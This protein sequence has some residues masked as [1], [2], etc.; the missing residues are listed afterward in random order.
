MKAC[1]VILG[2]SLLLLAGQAFAG[3]YDELQATTCK[4]QSGDGTGTGVLVT[5][6]VGHATR[7]WVWTAAHVVQDLRQ[8]D[9]TF[10]NATV[11]QEYRDGGRQIGGCKIEA[12]VVAY[13]DP[14]T[15]EDLALLE[16]LQDDWR[17]TSVSAK[18]DLTASIQPVGTKLVHVGCGLGFESLS[19][20]IVSQTD[21]QPPQTGKRFDQTTLPAYPGCSG[22]GVYLEDGR[23]VGMLTLGAGPGLNFIIP[24]RRIVPWAKKMGIAWALDPALPVSPIVDRESSV[25]RESS[26]AGILTDSATAEAE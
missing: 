4:V 16:V 8:P 18:F 21:V 25:T 24:M 3:V 22:G 10:R 20:G 2:L 13:S 6:Q 1:R 12:K 23:Y 17:P 11:S 9:G 14:D 19:L 26:E 5:R 7:T 15:G